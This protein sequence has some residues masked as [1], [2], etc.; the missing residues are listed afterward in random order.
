VL[1]VWSWASCLAFL[2]LFLHLYYKMEKIKVPWRIR[3]RNTCA[4]VWICHPKFIYWNLITKVMVLTWG[5]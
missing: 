2:S 3:S 1:P 5:V 4:L